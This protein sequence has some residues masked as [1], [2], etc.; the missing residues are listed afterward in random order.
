[1]TA[2]LTGV[3][4]MVH[5]TPREAKRA[6]MSATGM[7]WPGAMYGKKRTCSGRCSSLAAMAM[8]E[9]LFLGTQAEAQ[10]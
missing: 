2:A 4:R 9:P 8:P 6:A 1:M 10:S 5:L 7:R 3:V